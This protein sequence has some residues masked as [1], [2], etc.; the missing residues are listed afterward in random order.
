MVVCNDS[1]KT[2]TKELEVDEKNGTVLYATQISAN[3]FCCIVHRHKFINISSAHFLPYVDL[4]LLA[5]LCKYI[6]TLIWLWMC[7]PSVEVDP[8]PPPTPTPAASFKRPHELPEAAWLLD[9]VRLPRFI[10]FFQSLLICTL[11]SWSSGLQKEKCLKVSK[12]W[13]ALLLAAHWPVSHNAI[14]RP[15]SRQLCANPNQ[16]LIRFGS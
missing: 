4:D 5:L 6:F 14:Q 12:L 1:C 2:A 8:L 10:P 16:M 7:F 11:S 13:A 3:C 15:V 9:L